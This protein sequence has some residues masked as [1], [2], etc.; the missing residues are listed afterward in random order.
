MTAWF[1]HSLGSWDTAQSPA[2]VL[3]SVNRVRL[4]ERVPVV[5]GLPRWLSGKESSCQAG[6]LG[7]IAGSGRCPGEGNGNPFQYSCLRSP[8]DR[9]DWQTAVHG[10]TESQT[11]LSD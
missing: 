9:R 8:L 2:A 1:L 5:F 10:V 7:S 3:S 11:Q 6:D 4:Q